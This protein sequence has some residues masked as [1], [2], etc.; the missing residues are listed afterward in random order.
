MYTSQIEQLRAGADN[1][2]SIQVSSP[3][4]LNKATSYAQKKK[5]ADHYLKKKSG[6]NKTDRMQ[7]D[8]LQIGAESAVSPTMHKAQ[9]I[10]QS[11]ETRQFVY[12]SQTSPTNYNKT[13]S[14]KFSGANVSP[15]ASRPVVRKKAAGHYL[16]NKS[17]P[18]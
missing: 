10:D 15:S 13:S 8:F 17:S 18:T 16:T 9:T 6:E 3:V 11:Q 14:T 4:N 12:D 2:E 5:A 7:S 1:Q